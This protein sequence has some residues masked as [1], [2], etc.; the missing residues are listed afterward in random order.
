MMWSVS[1]KSIPPHSIKLIDVLLYQK[2]HALSYT[3]DVLYTSI[4]LR[5]MFLIYI[6]ITGLFIKGSYIGNSM[7]IL[8]L[9]KGE[10]MI[11]WGDLLYEQ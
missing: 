5:V 4:Y 1:I 7:F 3:I 10:Q 9:D 8:R 2:I 11:N 6:T